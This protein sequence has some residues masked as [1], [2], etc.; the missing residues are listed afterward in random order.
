M[1]TLTVRLGFVMGGGSHNPAVVGSAQPRGCGIRPP[2]SRN[3]AERLAANLNTRRLDDCGCVI[4][5]LE[6]KLLGRLAGDN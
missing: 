6:V 1:V 2:P 5:G 4:S 3:R